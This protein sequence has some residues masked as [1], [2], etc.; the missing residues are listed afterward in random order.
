MVWCLM[1][2]TTGCHS[3]LF[4]YYFLLQSCHEKY[5]FLEPKETETISQQY[6]S[7]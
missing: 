5:I 4:M 6:F 3:L 7:F 2:N 1:L